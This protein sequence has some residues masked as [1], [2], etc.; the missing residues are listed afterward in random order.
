MV[1]SAAEDV[2]VAPVSGGCSG[3]YLMVPPGISMLLMYLPIFVLTRSCQSPAGFAVDVLVEEGLKDN[4]V[5]SRLDKGH[6]STQHACKG[7]VESVA[8]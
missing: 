5:V 6:E 4:D 7:G 8:W 3:T 2:L 1:Q